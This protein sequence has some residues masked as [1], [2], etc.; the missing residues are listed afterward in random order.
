MNDMLTQFET[1][2]MLVM[3]VSH[4]KEMTNLLGIEFYYYFIIIV[5]IIHNFNID[6]YYYIH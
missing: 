6:F 2:Q 1:K 3:L 5:I 4:S